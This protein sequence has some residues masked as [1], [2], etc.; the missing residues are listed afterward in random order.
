MAA[1]AVGPRQITD[2]DLVKS[3][4][5]VRALLVARLEAMWQP[6]EAALDQARQVGGALPPDPRLLEIGLR[7]VRDE[8]ALYRLSRP[9][10]L[11][12]GNDEPELGAGVDRRA[13]IEAQLVEREERLRGDG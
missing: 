9:P 13:M 3:G 1:D 2:E 5:A 11:G 4:P 7:I 12:D 6:V 8:A 10:V